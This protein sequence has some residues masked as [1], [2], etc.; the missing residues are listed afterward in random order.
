M[1]ATVAMDAQDL[2]ETLG[3]LLEN[4][5]KWCKER[6]ALRVEDV[7]GKVQILIEDDGPGIPLAKRQSALRQ[8]AR[9]D[10]SVPGTGLGLSICLD[11]ISAYGGTMELD[12]SKELGGLAIRIR[13]PKGVSSKNRVITR[14]I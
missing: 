14:T 12:Q 3:N 10:T 4:A 7:D 1:T 5:F 9:L 8:G 2:E 13:L 6:V 11:L